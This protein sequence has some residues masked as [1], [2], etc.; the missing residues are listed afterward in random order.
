M[1]KNDLT[2]VGHFFGHFIK[3]ALFGRDN[4]YRFFEVA[5]FEYFE[6]IELGPFLDAPGPLIAQNMALS[7]EQLAL[8]ARR[9]HHCIS[10]LNCSK[11]WCSSAKIL[12]SS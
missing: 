5:K 1:G 2:I 10:H 9:T 12:K 11:G 4:G 6:I 3:I 8:Q 7:R